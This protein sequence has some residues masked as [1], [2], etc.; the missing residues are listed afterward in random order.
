VALQASLPP[1]FLGIF[2]ELFEVRFASLFER[3]LG[4]GRTGERNQHKR[5]CDEI[6]FPHTIFPLLKVPDSY[7]WL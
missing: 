6:Q 2:T 4:I 5:C 7:R 1:T 3:S